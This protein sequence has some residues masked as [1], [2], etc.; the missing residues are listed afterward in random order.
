MCNSTYLLSDLE[1][2]E[3]TIVSKVILTNSSRFV[4]GVGVTTATDVKLIES[5]PLTQLHVSSILNIHHIWPHEPIT[6]HV[7]THPHT[8]TH[9]GWVENYRKCHQIINHMARLWLRSS[10]TEACCIVFQ[11]I[12]RDEW[13][14]R[15][16]AAVTLRRW[17]QLCELMRIISGNLWYQTCSK[18]ISNMRVSA[19]QGQRAWKWVTA[20]HHSDWTILQ[21]MTDIQCQCRKFVLHVDGWNYRK[22][23]HSLTVNMLEFA[24]RPSRVTKRK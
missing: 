5:L 8:H 13:G 4:Y 7:H 18:S 22:C 3:E 23:Y 19:A 16:A 17:I 21:P 14:R 20:Q 11:Y 1:S 12:R 24:C 6:V 10:I 15:H 9:S 2:K